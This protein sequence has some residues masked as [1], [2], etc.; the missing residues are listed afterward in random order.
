MST[1]EYILN[2]IRQRC[3]NEEDDIS[4]D[5]GIESMTPHEKLRMVC[6]W[7]LGD[8]NWADQFIDWAVSCGMN[9]TDRE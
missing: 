2:K 4:G 9:I 8:D 5:F 6:G 3:G 7:E 1:P